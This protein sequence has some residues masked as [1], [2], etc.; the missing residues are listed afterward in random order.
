MSFKNY[1]KIEK[2]KENIGNA[3]PIDGEKIIS[4]EKIVIGFR[5]VF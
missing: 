2:L 4:D 1:L 3:F 5:D